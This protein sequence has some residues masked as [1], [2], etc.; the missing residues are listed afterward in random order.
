MLADLIGGLA[1]T[2][3]TLCWL[4]QAIHIIRTKEVAGVSVL[5]YSGFASGVACWLIY[6]L[7][8]E[9]WPLIG[10]NAI[11]FVLVLII[12][13]MKMHHTPRKA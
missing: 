8:I 7:M 13:F 11:T 9:S 10:A 4:P 5:A 12:I 6:G 1:A 3:T 2:L